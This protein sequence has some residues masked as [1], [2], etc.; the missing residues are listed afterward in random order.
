MEASILQALQSV[1]IAGLTQI[2]ALVSALGNYAFI[3]ILLAVIMLFFVGRRH[4]GFTIIAAVLVT[5]LLVGFVVQ[6]IVGRIRPFDAGIGIS[7]VM[8]VSRSGFSFPSFHA[9]TSFAAAMVI[10]MS[11]GRGPGVPAFIGA[12]LIGLSRLYLGVEYP[13]DVLAGAVIGVLIGLVTV[14]VYNQFLHDIVRDRVGSSGGRKKRRSV[15]R[16]RA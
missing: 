13:S 14:W 4:V 16:G 2:A 9:A 7:A 8:G 1:R 15:N 5:G 12:F 11:L 3:W 6:P 10:A